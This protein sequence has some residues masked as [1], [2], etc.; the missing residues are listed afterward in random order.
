MELCAG[1]DWVGE[2]EGGVQGSPSAQC[3]GGE[4]TVEKTAGRVEEFRT[5]WALTREKAAE[6]LLL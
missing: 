1:N 3:G 6:T 5:K 4:K 2:K